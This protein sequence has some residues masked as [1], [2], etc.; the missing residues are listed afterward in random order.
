MNEKDEKRAARLNEVYKYLFSNFDVKSKTQLA[1]ILRIQRTGLSSAFGGS[2]INL[3]DN[4]F[5]KI[6]AAFPGVF[7][8]DYL[9][10]GEGEL[11]ADEQKEPPVARSASQP[12]IDQSSMVNA[13]IA[14]H[15]A[16]MTAKNELIASLRESLE[17]KDELIES[18]HEQV[19]ELQRQ[20]AQARRS[21]PMTDYTYPVGVAEKTKTPRKK[22]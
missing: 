17:D 1:D 8:L 5:T 11:L 6:C 13:L 18:L 2:K 20:L 9:L 12:T 3:T 7:N 22:L 16:A 19:A 4:L 15:D 10:T 21:T 14:A